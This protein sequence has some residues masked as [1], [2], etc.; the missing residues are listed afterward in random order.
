MDGRECCAQQSAPSFGGSCSGPRGVGAAAF[1]HQITA[2]GHTT[3]IAFKRERQSSSAP[4]SST[5]AAAKAD[6]SPARSRQPDA[7][8]RAQPPQERQPPPRDPVGVKRCMQDFLAPK[9]PHSNDPHELERAGQG[10]L[11]HSGFRALQDVY[12]RI[13][14]VTDFIEAVN[15]SYKGS[16]CSEG[17][18]SP[19]LGPLS[20]IVTI[21]ANQ[22]NNGESKSKSKPGHDDRFST[23]QTPT[24]RPPIIPFNPASACSLFHPLSSRVR[25]APVR[26]QRAHRHVRQRAPRR[27]LQAARPP[28]S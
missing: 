4:E 3:R 14:L 17:D 16:V 27:P 9:G 23:A 26:E 6:S 21:L 10:A 7:P 12:L 8:P 13:G 2:R 28:S 24:N 22:A 5:P 20:T 19:F 25:A 18:S 1:F 11:R 15:R